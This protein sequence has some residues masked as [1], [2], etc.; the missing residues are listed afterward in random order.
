MEI[1]NI[2]LGY[3]YQRTTLHLSELYDFFYDGSSPL[4]LDH[5]QLE[6]LRSNLEIE[7][8][9]MKIGHFEYIDLYCA[10]GMRVKI[11]EDGLVVFEN[12]Y[13][14]RISSDLKELSFFSNTRTVLLSTTLVL[15]LLIM[16]DLQNLRLSGQ[17]MAEESGQEIFEFIGK[18]R[19]YNEH[20]IKAG[21]I[22]IPGHVEKY[23]L[24]QHKPGDK[25]D[26]KIVGL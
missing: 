6:K 15:V 24:G 1:K 7:K 3:W 8:V 4:A 18:L 11:Y 13:S 22:K 17:I 20:N 14:D 9:E 21:I 2:Y 19:Y 5:G 25:F 23:R 26:I 10:G 12:N 16:R